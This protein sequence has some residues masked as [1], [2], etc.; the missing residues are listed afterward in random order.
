[1]LSTAIHWNVVGHCEQIIFQGI[2]RQH[3]F[4][5]ECLEESTHPVAS[6]GS[7]RFYCTT[8]INEPFVTP[9]FTRVFVQSWARNPLP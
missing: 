4:Y 8:R 9:L 5:H 2:L 7:T 6:L 1:M 3:S